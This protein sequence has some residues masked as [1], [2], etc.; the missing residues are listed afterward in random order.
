MDTLE[1]EAELQK[2]QAE[3]C[4]LQK[5]LQDE[6]CVM[7]F[8]FRGNLLLALKVLCDQSLAASCGQRVALQLQEELEELKEDVERQSQMNGYRVV[9]CSTRRVD[10]KGTEAIAERAGGSSSSQ[11][12]CVS[13][14]CSEI[15]FQVEFKLAELKFGEKMKRTV[16]DVNIVMEDSELQSFSSFLS[17][18]EETQDLL[19]F[20]RTLRTFCDRC[21]ERRRTFTHFQPLNHCSPA[22]ESSP[23]SS[24]TPHCLLHCTNVSQH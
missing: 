4:E 6:Q 23:H 3:V 18:V 13:G 16:T 17:R 8:D 22:P 10:S 14:L 9:R 15:H 2:L 19:L 20:F 7:G 21:D 12:V 24:R 11:Q 5:Q 1:L